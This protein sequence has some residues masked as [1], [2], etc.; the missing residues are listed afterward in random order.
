MF[1]N[2]NCIGKN[3]SF[4]LLNYVLMLEITVLYNTNEQQGHA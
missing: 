3:G 1:R 4:E 2:K